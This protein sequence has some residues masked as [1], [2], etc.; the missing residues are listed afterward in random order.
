MKIIWDLHAKPW[1]SQPHPHAQVQ[2]PRILV[3]A[4][5]NA[6]VEVLLDRVRREGFTD[7]A[8]GGYHPPVL[9]VGSDSADKSSTPW[10]VDKDAWVSTRV[11]ELMDLSPAAWH[12]RYVDCGFRTVQT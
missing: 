9:R 8:G 11:R 12:A 1:Q 6:A 3:A 4:P 5:S 2:R 7:R 10:A